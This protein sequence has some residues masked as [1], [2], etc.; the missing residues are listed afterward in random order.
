MDSIIN[1]FHIDWKIIVA[2][3][4][5]FAIVFTVLYIFALKPLGKLMK[6]RTDKIARGVHDAK[7]NAELLVA[8]KAGYDEALAK[9]RREAQTILEEGK[10][11]AQAKHAEILEAGK[12]EVAALISSGKKT[13]E[14]EKVRMVEEAKKEIVSL[15]VQTTKKILDREDISSEE[16]IK[17]LKAIDSSKR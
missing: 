8:T 4:I 12:A 3:A 11:A 6:E 10:K 5:N 2:Q 17:D 7:T 14:A 13:L 9:A 16:V 15:V 1:T